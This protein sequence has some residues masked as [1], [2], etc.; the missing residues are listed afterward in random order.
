MVTATEPETKK[1]ANLK[2][3]TRIAL[4]IEYDG[5]NYYGFQWQTNQPT[6][7]KEI[8]KA[9][10]KLT[11][12]ES[13]VAAAS[14]T[15]TGVHARG[16]VV[17]FRTKSSLPYTTFVKGLNYYLPGD[18]AVKNAVKVDDSFNVRSK[19]LRREYSYY[20]VNSQIRSPLNRG[21]THLV[22]GQLDIG[23]MN[24]A[25]RVLIGKHDFASFVTCLESSLKSTVRHV[26]QAKVAKDGNLVTFNIVANSFLPHQVRN[27]VGA[28]IRVGL[29]KMTTDEFYG[30]FEAKRPS[31]AGPTAPACGLYL[32]R[33]IYPHP[34][35][36]IF[37]E[38]L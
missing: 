20:I 7:Q 5:T 37:N 28:L 1:A 32:M 9:I 27:T 12:E 33:I 11:G 34:W 23:V 30:I 3:S 22:T 6:V 10:G 18:I 26:Y 16:Q 21:F 17:S 2:T 19:A 8:E 4:I 35:E 14:R 38:N 29:G 24:E 31:L 13:R 36:E 15:D 25:C